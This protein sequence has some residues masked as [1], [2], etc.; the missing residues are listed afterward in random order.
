MNDRFLLASQGTSRLRL[1]LP[2]FGRLALELPL[3][4]GP[5]PNTFLG[6]E[7][8]LEPEAS[9]YHADDPGS[10]KALPVGEPVVQGGAELRVITE[11]SAERS[12][13][14]VTAESWRRAL[15]R[16]PNGCALRVDGA[17]EPTQL[18]GLWSDVAGP[19]FGLRAGRGWL[20]AFADEDARTEARTQLLE[21]SRTQGLRLVI[22]PVTQPLDPGELEERAGAHA[23]AVT[24]AHADPAM[25][26][27]EALIDRAA[28]RPANVVI[29]GESGTGKDLVAQEI[30]RRSGRSSRVVRTSAVAL[31]EAEVLQASLR[32][33]EGGVLIIDEI[34]ALDPKAQLA[35]AHGLDA[36]EGRGA[37]IRVLSLSST[38][39]SQVAAAGQFRKELAYRLEALS[40]ALPPL[41]QRRAEIA[42]LARRFAAEL[43]TT[44]TSEAVAA[45]E[46]HDFPGNVRE[47]KNLIGR[48]H[49]ASGGVIGAEHLPTL[50]LAPAPAPTSAGEGE[51]RSLKEKLAEMEKLRIIEAL[52][53]HKTQREAALA[54]E[55]PM[56]TFLS[57]LD[58]YGIPR[59]RGGGKKE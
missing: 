39:L 18:A 57:R 3:A 29:V 11:P 51:G 32:D 35:L 7:V 54:L 48:A 47:L 49:L 26:A 20:L 56:S 59:A 37:P 10:A 31:L 41:R 13:V 4:A 6:L 58:A 53:T 34:T 27:V 19:C 44:L 16:L 33:A 23:H 22:T 1:A 52:R 40:I 36:A 8:L 17:A 5:T 42:P 25:L 55:M 28:P 14:W 9:V 24:I 38:T 21:L 46:A 45:L 12:L 30:L 50:A 2:E 43:S 15:A